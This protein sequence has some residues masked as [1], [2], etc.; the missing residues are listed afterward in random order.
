MKTSLG[1]KSYQTG[2]TI[3]WKESLASY[4]LFAIASPGCLCF[5]R[6]RVKAAVAPLAQE[7]PPTALDE[8]VAQLNDVYIE[9]GT[10]MFMR[11]VL[12]LFSGGLRH[13]C[14]A[15]LRTADDAGAVP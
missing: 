9:K 13:L 8:V 15:V 1:R 10:P 4:I 3:Y 2:R 5:P 14:P 7:R 11:T 12:A 6:S